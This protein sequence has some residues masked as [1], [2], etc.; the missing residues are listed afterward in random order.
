MYSISDASDDAACV[1]RCLEGDT[2]AFEPLVMRY[3]RALFTV[4]LRLTANREDAR[5]ATQNAFIRAFE[6]LDTFDPSRRFF[7]WLY[8][9]A[10][11][12]SLNLR[13]TQKPHDPIDPSM[14]LVARATADPVER[15]ELSARVQAA[16]MQL[17]FDQREVIVLRHFAEMSYEEIGDALSLPE[18]TVKS[19]LFAARQRLGPLL[20]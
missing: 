14:G 10:V 17:T 16:L 9:I 20:T 6:R 13:R 19:R 4:A 3:Q 12:E 11:N 8:R 5:D 15:A 2:A 7:S 18:K 1:A